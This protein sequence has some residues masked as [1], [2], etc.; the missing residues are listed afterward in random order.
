MHQHGVAA[1]VDL[2]GFLLLGLIGSVAHCTA[3]CSPFVLF[4]S[5]RF[6]GRSRGAGVLGAQGWYA[7]GRVT[8]YAILG[9]AAGAAGAAFQIAGAL[10][11]LHRVAAAVAGAALVASA[12]AGLFKSRW[13]L[14]PHGGWF[15][16]VTRR[17]QQRLPG[18]PYFVGLV[19]G[20]LPCGLIYTAV[21]GA[22]AR[23]SAIGGAEALL[24]FGVG[25]VPAL[26]GVALA[27]EVL[28]TRRPAIHRLSQV[29]VL[30][31][32]LWYLWSGLV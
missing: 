26:F 4:I 22:V 9:A 15:G 20:L 7:A 13:S 2:A 17:F 18:H 25:T 3:M 23:G 5:S 10:M 6:A 12:L 24:L 16:S 11:G 27:N 31:M 32:G 1:N 21:V 8:T 14:E 19:L 29:F 30:V 28:F